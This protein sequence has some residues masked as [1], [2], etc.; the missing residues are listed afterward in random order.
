MPYGSL[1]G[2]LKTKDFTRLE[3]GADEVKYYAKGVGVVL[4]NALHEKDRNELVRMTRR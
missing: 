2:L 1:R 3:P 4:E